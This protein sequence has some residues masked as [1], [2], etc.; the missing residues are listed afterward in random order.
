MADY[1]SGNGQFLLDPGVEG[2]VETDI[3]QVSRRYSCVQGLPGL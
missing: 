1:R 3:G 2:N